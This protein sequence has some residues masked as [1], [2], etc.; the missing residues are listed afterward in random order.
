MS[1]VRWGL[2]AAGNIA[3]AFAAGVQN[4]EL[5]ELYAVGSR[6]LARSEAF[7]DEFDIPKRYGSYDELLADPDVD[8][9]YISTQHPQHAE[10]AIKTAEAR[11][12]ILCEKPLAMNAADA[13][14]IIDA[15]QH[16]D[17]F[18]ME[19]FM[20]RCNP[21]TA[22]LLEIIREKSIGDVRL[23]RAVFAFDVG[24]EYEGRAT[25][26]ELGGGGILDV[27]CY[28]VSMCRLIAGTASGVDFLDPVEVAGVGRIG[29]YGS[30]EWAVANLKFENDIVAEVSTAVRI[31][32]DS[33]VTIFGGNGS[34]HIPAPW[35]C[36]GREGGDGIIE[37]N[38]NGE[39]PRI[40]KVP[41]G[42]L[43]AIEADTVARN[44]VNR[45]AP[46]P[47]MSWADTLGNM[48]T[49]DAWRRCIGLS[50]PHDRPEGR[51]LT[52]VGRTLQKSADAPMKYGAIAGVA[53]PVSRLVMGCDNQL[54]YPQLEVIAD[55]FFEAGGNTFDTAFQY[56]PDCERFVGDWM[57]ARGVR[58]D[59]VVIM[60]AAH[61]P[62]CFPDRLTEQLLE[63][64]AR[65]QVD[66][67]DIF[68]I[69][70]DNPDVPVGEFVDVLNEHV[71]AGRIGVFGGSNWTIERLRAANE[72]AAANEKQGFF[73]L[74]NQLSL[75]D[76]V[77]P[78]WGG[79]ISAKG[80][81]WSECL[82]ESKMTLLAWSSQARGFFVPGRAAPDKR[83][84]AELVNSWYS[85]D[86]FERQKR[87]IELAQ[88]K[89]VLPINIA[90][91]WV[92]QRAYP[93]FALIGPRL[94]S[95]LRS[96][97]DSLAV[98]LTPDEMAWLDLQA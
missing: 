69:H 96:S 76:M 48:R 55:A 82:Q 46:S 14:A 43:Y 3:H 10:W 32:L 53:Q 66:R 89:G 18:L 67:A 61:S 1:K 57:K 50:Y 60:K 86:N 85:D 17:V 98:E 13:A 42:W 34:I 22:R 23:I 44:I 16:N 40:E 83:D 35:F 30:D 33:T 36:A 94:L 37:I 63:S 65:M 24:D 6:D 19:A 25:N 4:S 72:Y 2:L 64:Q 74:S 52:V 97:L 12:H 8:A 71:E 7:A 21:L 77:N 70:R 87:A 68:F 5:G 31:M 47:A 75:A 54:D 81:E 15:A 92:L 88:K 93:T 58:D 80:D 41:S 38:V 95:E 28:C 9:V 56:G 39:E 91:A 62:N 79:C 49:L 59:V 51:P 29:R 73:V 78:V 90:G 84:D 26:R 11:K 45:Q 20:Y 27:G